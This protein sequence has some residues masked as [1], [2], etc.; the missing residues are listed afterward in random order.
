MHVFGLLC[1]TRVYAKPERM[2]MKH[3]KNTRAHVNQNARVQFVQTKDTRAL[4]IQTMMHMA[5][6]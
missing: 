5:A 4:F 2:P 3:A 1:I 6:D